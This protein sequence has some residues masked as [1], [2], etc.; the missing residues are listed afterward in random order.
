MYITIVLKISKSL[1]H[2]ECHKMTV[3]NENESQLEKLKALSK[4]TTTI[5]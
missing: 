2:L 5:I 3:T 4:H 1:P